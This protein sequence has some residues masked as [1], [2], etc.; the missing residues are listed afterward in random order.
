MAY[1]HLLLSLL[2]QK[3]EEIHSEIHFFLKS[4]IFI[5]SREYQAAPARN[6]TGIGKLNNVPKTFILFV[7]YRS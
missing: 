2:Y 5:P 3:A 4:N 6:M 1:K 7:R